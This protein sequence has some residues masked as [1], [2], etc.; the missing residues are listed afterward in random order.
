MID[1]ENIVLRFAVTGPE[2]ED[3]RSCLSALYSIREG[4]QP[5]DRAFGLSTEF[6]GKPLPTAQNEL[7]LEI[8]QKTRIYEPRVSVKQVLFESEAENGRIRPVVYV[9]RSEGDE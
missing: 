3:I 1:T 5:L 2:A 4:T 6:I 9:E 7:A 8:I